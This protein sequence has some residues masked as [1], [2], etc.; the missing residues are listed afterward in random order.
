MKTPGTKVDHSSYLYG[1]H[2]QEAILLDVPTIERPEGEFSPEETTQI[3]LR[4]LLTAFFT[5]A[6]KRG[7]NDEQQIAMLEASA[8][9]L[10]TGKAAADGKQWRDE[11]IAEDMAAHPERYTDAGKA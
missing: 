7:L 10:R 2:L 3:L 11:I 8:N 9:K 4:G 5:V 1:H 6:D